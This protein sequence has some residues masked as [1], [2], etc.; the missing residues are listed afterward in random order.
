MLRRTLF[1]RAAI[2]ATF[3]IVITI[4]LYLYS[5]QIFQFLGAQVGPAGP[6][7][8][9]GVM[10]MGDI[11]SKNL[12]DACDSNRQCKDGAQCAIC[13]RLNDNAQ[14]CR[15]VEE[16]AG[17]MVLNN[18]TCGNTETPC[19]PTG[20]AANDCCRNDQTCKS[21]YDASQ[22]RDV[23][24]C[25]IDDPV[26]C[27]PVGDGCGQFSNNCCLTAICTQDEG[28][29]AG[30]PWGSCELP[31]K[32][33][34]T[35][36]DCKE[37]ADCCPGL[38]CKGK[39]TGK[40]D[41][42]GNPIIG[43][44]KDGGKCAS[45]A[46]AQGGDNAGQANAGTTA[47]GAGGNNGANGMT[48][49]GGGGGA[50][51]GGGGVPGGG[52][53]PGGGGGG[54]PGGGGGTNGVHI[55]P[56]PGCEPDAM[57]SLAC[58]YTPNMCDGH[59]QCIAPCLPTRILGGFA[60]ICPTKNSSSSSAKSSQSS[61]SSSVVSAQKSSSSQSNFCGSSCPAIP[62][63]IPQGCTLVK[64]NEVC[65]CL[66]L[67]CSSSSSSKS[68]SSNSFVSASPGSL[69]SINTSPASS[70]NSSSS[71]ESAS[72]SSSSSPH[73]YCCLS[74]GYACYGPFSDTWRICPAEVLQTTDLNTC[75]AGCIQT[76]PSSGSSSSSSN[77]SSNSSSSSAGPLC[78]DFE[79]AFYGNDACNAQG[80]ADGKSYHCESDHSQTLCYR[81][82]Q[83]TSSSSSNA[84]VPIC[85]GFE[86][87]FYGNDACAQKTGS[88]GLPQR[89]VSDGSRNECYSCVDQGSSSSSSTNACTGLECNFF[90]GKEDCNGQRDSQGNPL[91]CQRDDSKPSCYSC[92]PPASSLSS[93][94]ASSSQHSY[95]CNGSECSFNGGNEYCSGQTG[96]NGLSLRCVADTSNAACFSCVPTTTS[97][98]S[99][100]ACT[101]L[102]CD[103]Y[104]G[105]EACG[106]FNGQDG[107]PL[108]CVKDFT[109][110]LCIRCLP[111]TPPSSS[112]FSSSSSSSSKNNSSSSFIDC[113]GLECN[114]FGGREDCNAQRDSNGLPLACVAD[115]T[116]QKCYRC[117]PTNSSS[118]L[119]SSRS[120]N[121]SSSSSSSSS[122]H[123]SSSSSSSG[124]S[125]SS[126]SSSQQSSNSNSSSSK[127]SSKS[128]SNSSSRNSSQGSLLSASSSAHPC[129][130]ASDC[131]LGLR[132]E[133]NRCTDRCTNNA[134]CPSGQCV[135]NRCTSVSCGNGTR[136]AGE[137]CDD[138][139]RVDTDQCSNACRLGNGAA[140][141]DSPQCASGLCQN[142]ICTPCSSNSMC[143]SG[144]CENG[145]CLPT[146]RCGNG[147]L[148]ATEECDDGNTRDL[149][150]CTADCKLEKGSCGDGKV[151]VLLDEQCEPSLMNQ[152]L[153]YDCDPQTCHFRSKFC[154]NGIVDA[155]EECDT[156][157]RNADT[158][159]AAPQRDCRTDCSA[160]RCG[161]H[162]ID[163]FEQCDDGNR[164]PGDGCD[165]FCRIEAP[166]A[167]LPFTARTIDLP[168]LP[169]DSATTIATSH[170]P[171][172]NTGPGAVALMATGAAAGIAW[173]RKRRKQR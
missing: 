39:D 122:S 167:T 10:G 129:S 145:K 62:N 36:G 134:E 165:R 163:A 96:S 119:S 5:A 137:V 86:C 55:E 3:A 74:P 100:P 21:Q 37:N 152:S 34:K 58:C 65:S 53:I 38:T 160:P 80:N 125:S 85:Y 78:F 139:N 69:S 142:G 148:D 61:S 29:K 43:D 108:R 25:A 106:K 162:I 144:R 83:N 48:T 128:S 17:C 72:Q 93:S 79:C 172:G 60:C 94:S 63:P 103:F 32:C 161:D 35:G 150:G 1:R 51:P 147:V 64:L 47:G 59:I 111:Q 92:I 77:S 123:S 126:S 11:G 8:A 136:E 30:Q 138:G 158:P 121:F 89:C 31:L 135:D 166:A 24:Y 44:P 132:C 82:V 49:I 105:N 143:T 120:S 54:N 40:K 95:D 155:G 27:I 99:L 117:N 14:K 131:P 170:A 173:M 9:G 45:N 124:F 76:L 41:A 22:N 109:D 16:A 156:G 171:A 20:G 70:S 153:P 169:N 140:C 84:S 118:S 149:D 115:A 81:C 90:G 151:E 7:G 13:A 104:G 114:F 42:K 6:P 26:K 154:G 146:F 33:A 87:A 107:L 110:P 15:T 56:V 88:N 113:T 164:V 168:V 23:Y 133:D 18:R 98:S 101:G 141:T 71:N 159:S 73:Y 57:G 75:N 102:E 91:L 12:G 66:K 52:G 68:S 112:S 28:A 130:T 97:S 127:F 46:G 4:V 157:V 67:V 116:V 50:G 2:G 19:G